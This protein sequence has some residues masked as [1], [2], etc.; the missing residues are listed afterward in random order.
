MSSEATFQL[1]HDTQDQEVF[2][3]VVTNNQYRLPDKLPADSLVI[4]VGANIGAFAV[5]CLMRGAGTVVCFEP[6][7]RN[8]VQL[9]LNTAAWVGKVAPFNAAVWRS[10]FAEHVEFVG[11]DR[12]T[13]CGG[14]RPYDPVRPGWGVPS[15]DVVAMGLDQIIDLATTEHKRAHILKVDAEGSEYPILYTSRLLRKVDNLIVETHQIPDSFGD[16]EFNLCGY[17]SKEACAAGMV[18]FLTQQGFVVQ[19]V[20]ENDENKICNIHFATRPTPETANDPS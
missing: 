6:C 8:F 20:A 12:Y 3:S 4:D 1:R 13:A 10:D 14:V 19:S 11:H 15:V 5:A 16:K 9:C 7:Q 2:E 18:Q 17:N